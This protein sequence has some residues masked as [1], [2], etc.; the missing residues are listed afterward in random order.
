MAANSQS[1]GQEQEQ[2][3]HQ[4]VESVITIFPKQTPPSDYHRSQRSDSHESDIGSDADG[5]L[6]DM[7]GAGDA[8]RR[9]RAQLMASSE[10]RGSK[11]EGHGRKHTRRI[12][13]E[14]H[15]E[16]HKHGVHTSEDGHGSDFSSI[17]TS[18]DVELSNMASDDATSD[19]EETG[20]T[21][22][23][24]QHRK[25]RRR[26]NML[27]DARVA[28]NA[29]SA[30]QEQKEADWTV[31]KSMIINVLL[32]GSWYLFSLSISIVRRQIKAESQILLTTVAVQ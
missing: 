24:K 18:D 17:S 3:L 10:N 5:S 12:G 11:R 2:G 26:K 27:L 20:L 30:D 25:K 6:S 13:T 29:M 22:K 28:G 4:S 7:D 8:Y 31:L 23:E 9:R 16:D 14:L 32:I 15:G 19:D 1:Q 21:K